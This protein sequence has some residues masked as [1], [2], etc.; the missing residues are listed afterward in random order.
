MGQEQDYEMETQNDI[1]TKAKADY[2]KRAQSTPY[3][4]SVKYQQLMFQLSKIINFS[5][6]VTILTPS[7]YLTFS[8]GISPKISSF[9]TD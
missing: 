5:R 4:I 2:P 9:R 7:S 6:F 3:N 8:S 1:L